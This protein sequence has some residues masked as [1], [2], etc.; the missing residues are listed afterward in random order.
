MLPLTITG[1]GRWREGDI[2]LQLCGV[3]GMRKSV[4]TETPN[5]VFSCGNVNITT[6]GGTSLASAGKCNSDD[7]FTR[8]SVGSS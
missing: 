8:Q 7:E 2:F 5:T 3:S 1:H 4:G 6:D